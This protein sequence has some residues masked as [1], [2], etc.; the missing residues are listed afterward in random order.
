MVM[1]NN[2]P[3]TDPT[4]PSRTPDHILIDIT[5]PEVTHPVDPD[6][7]DG[8]ITEPV[9]GS[10]N[11]VAPGAES[12]NLRRSSREKHPPRKLTYD[13]LGEPL[14]LAISSFLQALGTAISLVSNPDKSDMPAETHAV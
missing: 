8:P 6:D 9:L 11:S 7:T 3:V 14:I 13:E 1:K 10:T 4:S 5:E 2:V 12:V